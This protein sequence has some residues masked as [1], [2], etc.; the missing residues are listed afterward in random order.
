LKALCNLPLDPTSGSEF[1]TD[2][3][4]KQPDPR[5]DGF[6]QVATRRSSPTQRSG[7]GSAPHPSP[8]TLKNCTQGPATSCA[9]HMGYCAISRVARF[10]RDSSSKL[11]K[12]AIHSE[13]FRRH[14]SSAETQGFLVY[15][16]RCWLTEIY[17]FVRSCSSCFVCFIAQIGQKTIQPV[18]SM[19]NEREERVVNQHN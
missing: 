19:T 1:A 4:A 12:S 6:L 16:P 15:T 9:K 14:I 7:G 5:S 13:R 11:G 17:Y 10:T 3:H 2:T 8:T 18:S